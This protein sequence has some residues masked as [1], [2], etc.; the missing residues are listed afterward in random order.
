MDSCGWLLSPQ[1]CNG[2][3][4]WTRFN[5]VAG[6][7]G[8]LREEEDRKRD[9][10][11][12]RSCGGQCCIS[13]NRIMWPQNSQSTRVDG[14]IYRIMLWEC[15]FSS[16]QLLQSNVGHNHWLQRTKQ[17]AGINLLTQ[18]GHTKYTANGQGRRK[19]AFYF[20]TYDYI[21][22]SPLRWLLLRWT[23]LMRHLRCSTSTRM[24]T[25]ETLI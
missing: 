19:S 14:Q 21:S 5:L 15:I 9:L 18:D 11:D 12:T 7:K 25:G 22:S 6:C 1:N 20:P 2:T 23:L 13:K 3:D 16:G 4:V 10:R 24:A 17:G 8:P